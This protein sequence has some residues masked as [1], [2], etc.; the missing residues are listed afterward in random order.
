MT[1]VA[2]PGFIP[3][4][5]FL[6]VRARRLAID[7]NLTP[8]DE[9]PTNVAV[10]SAPIANDESSADAVVRVLTTAKVDGEQQIGVQIV[11]GRRAASLDP[12]TR[13]RRRAERCAPWRC[14]TKSIIAIQLSGTARLGLSHRG[15]CRQGPLLATATTVMA[16]PWRGDCT[17]LS[18]RSTTSTTSL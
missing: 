2:V 14:R 5:R 10:S 7:T 6:E 17:T 15:D 9:H 12:I 13:V 8:P 1:D 16:V 18:S 3:Y 11:A 4:A